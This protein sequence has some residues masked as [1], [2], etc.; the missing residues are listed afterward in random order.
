MSY[1]AS[2]II[3]L[4]FSVLLIGAFSGHAHANDLGN[5]S[6]AI[7]TLYYYDESTG[8]KGDIVPL[9]DNPQFVNADPDMAA[10]GMFTFTRVPA[11]KYYLEANNSGR[12]FF[13][14]A[15]V[16]QGT[17]TA[18]IHIPGGWQ[19]VN[20]TPVP[21]ATPTV[22]P[23]PLLPTPSPSPTPAPRTPG[24]EALAASMAF[25]IAVMSIKRRN[26]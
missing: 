19:Q 14:I 16:Y 26:G 20:A 6:G 10:P 3:L 21:T 15:D 25:A 2:S 1:K 7:V 17:T 13:A 22:S 12:I 18:N 4:L 11:G 9:P 5:V 24:F 23:P 8:G